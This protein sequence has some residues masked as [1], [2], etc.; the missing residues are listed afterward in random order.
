MKNKIV[1]FGTGGHARVVTDILRV[2]AEFE[3][4]G[5]VTRDK[6]TEFMGKPVIQDGGWQT[7]KGC[8]AIVAIGDN[9]L[10]RK[11]VDEVRLAGNIAFAKA[12]HPSAVVAAD[13]EIGMGTV[14]MAGACIGIGTRIGDHCVVNTRA[15]VDHDGKIEEFVT[16]GPGCV[17]G[18]D[19]RVGRSAWIGMGATVLEGI[20]IGQ[21]TMIGAASLVN[22]HIPDHA[23]GFG[24]PWR[25]CRDR[26]E[27]ETFIS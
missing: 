24:V 9:S 5:Y 11:V 17:L 16:L 18:G 7:L 25:K 3:I 1:I 12:I 6:V 2:A 10:R 21:N 23:H 19:V 8:E 13:V 20:R 4:L 27:G 26:R 15:A 22:D 14:V